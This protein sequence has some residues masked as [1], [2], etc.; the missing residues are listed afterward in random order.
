MTELRIQN[1]LAEGRGTGSLGS[2]RPW[3]RIH[4]FPSRGRVHRVR[5]LTTGRIHHL[6]SDGE[7]RFFTYC[8]WSDAVQDIREQFP[9]DRD[10]T[11]RI[12]RKLGI[13]H[14][15]TAD[16]TPLVMT[17]D[18][19]LV[20]GRGATRKLIARTY[21]PANDL[22]KARVLEKLEIERRYWGGL[23][24]DWG[25]VTEQQ[26]NRVLVRNVSSVRAFSDL[27]G[28]QG[29]DR[30]TVDHIAA[31]IVAQR[32]SLRQVTLGA[33]CQ[34]LDRRH[35]LQP[36]TAFAIAR[37]LI[38]RKHLRTDMSDPQPVGQRRLVEF[39]RTTPRP[40]S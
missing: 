4:D 35:D 30:S 5:G 34:H 20:V 22:R 8:D 15:T 33:L 39:R 3:I 6:M 36:G 26:V 27:T 38:A 21:K 11:Y 12:A 23:E 25:I 17:T 29:L 9:L 31:Q 7:Y 32:S 1:H 10:V 14:P 13:R 40:S 18:F 37:H 28:L 24:V 19:L 2:Y 16:A